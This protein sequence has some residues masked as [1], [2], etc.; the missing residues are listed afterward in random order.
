MKVRREAVQTGAA[1]R[2][3]TGG[4]RSLTQ[5]YVEESSRAQRSRHAHIR[6]SGR[7]FMN[8]AGQLLWIGM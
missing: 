8:K 4:F 3:A 1:A 2:R 6:R 7:S 5:Q